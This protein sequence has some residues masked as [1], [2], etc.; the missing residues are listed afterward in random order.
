M[1]P[2]VKVSAPKL[3]RHSHLQRCRRCIYSCSAVSLNC[4]QS[5]YSTAQ[6]KSEEANDICKKHADKFKANGVNGRKLLELKDQNLI[7]WGITLQSDR[8][9]LLGEITK[10][11]AEASAAQGWQHPQTPEG[12]AFASALASAS[13][14][15]VAATVMHVFTVAVVMVMTLIPVAVLTFR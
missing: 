9:V 12:D 7:D 8:E 3:W 15:A 1:I 4:A 13:G 10:L 5:S 14:V 11:N 6:M 2:K